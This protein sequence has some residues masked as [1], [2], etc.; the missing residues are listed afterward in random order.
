MWD[1]VTVTKEVLQALM[2]I[3]THGPCSMSDIPAVL[4][5]LSN[6]DEGKAIDWITA[7]QPEYLRGVSVGFRPMQESHGSTNRQAC[8]V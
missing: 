3:R 5:F 2:K 7:N 1:K 6:I 4:R 8:L